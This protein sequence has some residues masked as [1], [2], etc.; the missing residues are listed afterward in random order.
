MDQ[1]TML[2]VNSVKACWIPWDTINFEN[3]NFCF[4]VKWILNCCVHSYL[5]LDWLLTNSLHSMYHYLKTFLLF[6]SATG[7]KG[8]AIY[9]E[10]GSADIPPHIKF[11]NLKCL[12]KVQ[13]GV[14][15]LTMSWKVGKVNLSFQS[16]IQNCQLKTTVFK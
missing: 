6:I 10:I 9:V 12:C 7:F 3:K 4:L 14:I 15:G 13:Y 16:Y 2:Y 8:F 1:N 5:F 11:I